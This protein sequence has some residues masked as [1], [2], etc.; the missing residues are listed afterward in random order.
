MLAQTEAGADEDVASEATS[1]PLCERAGDVTDAESFCCWPPLL[2]KD[3]D[4]S[5][6]G[7]GDE[8]MGD[9]WPPL[10]RLSI[11]VNDIED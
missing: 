7:V 5:S 10:L 8:P 6:S 2:M 3:D 9:G 1:P 11:E 4:N